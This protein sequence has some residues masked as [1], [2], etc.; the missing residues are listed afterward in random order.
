MTQFDVDV[1]VVGGGP[2]GLAASIEA[3][4]A[5]FS[6]AVLDP[7]SAPVD[8]A[9]GEG[10]MPPARAALH[11]LGVSP[12]GVEFRGIR[13]LDGSRQ[14]DALF[15]AGPGLGVRRPVLSAALAARAEAVGV[16]REPVSVRSVE[17][18]ADGVRAVSDGGGLRARWLLAA[19]GLHSPV[20]R[21]LGL[22]RRVRAGP[23]YGLRRH[24]RVGPWTDLVEVHWA[25]GAEAYL[26]PVAPDV[27][28]VAVLCAG[29]APFESWLAR[30][31][32]LVER[33]AD[34]VTPV[35]GAG[36]LRVAASRRVAGR[37]LLVGDAAGYVDALTG[38]G[39]AVG[40][41]EARAAVAALAAGRPEQYEAAWRAVTRRYR[42]MTGGLLWAAGRPLLHRTIVPAAA[43]LPPVFRGI[44]NSLG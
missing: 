13:Y 10:L 5:G 25:D 15:R 23:R 9:C 22:E 1:L 41:K 16:R 3:V 7:R 27:V 4:G 6:C 35:R 2:V 43:A 21:A 30:F 33:L 31:P 42:L 19:D 8:K 34:P 28:G 32:A 14:V 11:R 39:I 17:Q 18:D 36:P 20:R 12:T 40:L 37:V 26:T 38:E 24:Y 29:G 44:V